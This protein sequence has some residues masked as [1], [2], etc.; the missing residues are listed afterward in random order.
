MTA[1]TAF[2][3]RLRP[4]ATPVRLVALLVALT[5]AAGTALADEPAFFRAQVP[6]ATP[7]ATPTQDELQLRRDQAIFDGVDQLVLTFEEYNDS[8]IDGTATL[9]DLGD[10]TLIAI[11]IEG[12]GESHPAFIL[13]GTCG[14]TEP[15]PIERLGL[16]DATG[17]S[18]SLVERSLSDLI[19]GGDYTI[20][21]RLSPN[22]LGTLV[23]CVNIEGTTVP[24]TPAPGS[25]PPTVPAT[26]TPAVVPTGEGGITETPTAAET[27]TPTETA[28]PTETPTATATST[29]TETPTATETPTPTE[30]V[31]PRETAT[32]VE[33]GTGGPQVAPG[34]VASLPLG[35]YSGLGVSGTVSL[36]AIDD[37]ST[38]VTLTLT[39]DAVTGNHIAHL[40]RGTCGAPEDDGTIY[41]ATVDA[42]GVS[43][44]TVDLSLA[45]LLGD[46]W[47]VNVHRSDADYD[48]WL[49]C[50]ELGNAT[51]GMTGVVDVT[52]IVGG[53][54]TGI[55]QAPVGGKGATTATSTGSDGTS[56]VGGKGESVP[57]STL[58]QGVGVG[59]TLPWPDTPAQAIAWSLGLFSLV[60]V[61][62]A[63]MLRRLERSH[64]PTSRWQRLGL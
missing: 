14:N 15:E 34:A 48:T 26:G 49:V 37:D 18:L 42:N 22:E 20:D 58:T 57:T 1:V 63:I 19:D 17:E 21:L 24:A 54:G 12:G 10:D 61:A 60:L 52:P 36:L 13:E 9:Y 41:L 47:I 28:S 16:V 2:R 3:K 44:S 55:T 25:T 33:D 23:A 29:P 32:A 5:L 7:P 39:G 11:A 56:G 35:D 62:S 46:G 43:D 8:G 6:E 50:G 31:S 38:R 45:A 64:R 4:W 53:K 51:I 59:S 40:H 30:T 27:P